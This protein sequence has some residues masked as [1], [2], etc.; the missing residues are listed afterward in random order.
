MAWLGDAIMALG[1][2]LCVT[3]GMC[4][5]AQAVLGG[6]KATVEAD[7]AQMKASLKISSNGRFE[8]HELQT[9]GGNVVREFVSP[10]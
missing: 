7:Q 9:S 3:L 5:A 1:V 8:V 2:M 6:T 10:A 4:G